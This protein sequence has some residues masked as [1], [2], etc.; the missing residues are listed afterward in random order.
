MSRKKAV[1]AA[2]IAFLVFVFVTEALLAANE[3]FGMMPDEFSHFEVVFYIYRHGI[4]PTGYEPQIQVPYWGASYA[5]QPILTYIIQG[6]LMRFIDL[7]TNNI[8]IIAYSARL[9]NC[10][11]GVVMA[12]FVMK[13]AK[14][15]W[16]DRIMQWLFTFMIVLLPENLYIHSYIN[17]ESM[18]AMS[19]AIIIYALFKGEEDDYSVKTSVTLAIGISLCLLSYYNAYG[20]VLIAFLCFMSHFIFKGEKRA[21]W[22][23]AGFVTLLVF[24]M[25]GWWFIRSG[26]LYNG[27]IFGLKARTALAIKDALPQYSPLT[28]LTYAKQGIPLKDMLLS[29][30]YLKLVYRSFICIMGNFDI[31]T[32]EIVYRIDKYLIIIAA[33]FAVLPIKNTV[34]YWKKGNKTAGQ[35]NRVQALLFADILITLFLHMIY[36]YGYDWQPQGRYLLPMLIPM[37]YFLALGADKGGQLIIFICEKIGKYCGNV[38]RARS[39]TEGVLAERG[40]LPEEIRSSISGSKGSDAEMSADM[41]G[42]GSSAA[43]MPDDASSKTKSPAVIIISVLR[44]ALMVYIVGVLIYTINTRVLP[45]YFGDANFKSYIGK[46]WQQVIPEFMLK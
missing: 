7:F 1:Q 37:M 25:A 29:N 16:N 39:V 30:D 4:I 36:S 46:T 15:L 8:Y 18:A 31:Q 45:L 13:T 10:L 28:K 27:D 3:A 43:E 42:N 44:I 12:W 17:T 35:K 20:A 9:V 38:Q 21:M 2:E 22:K 26:I 23:K 5:F 40:V 33:I 32:A 11:F 24:I 34:A 41:S 19:V 14:L 6:W